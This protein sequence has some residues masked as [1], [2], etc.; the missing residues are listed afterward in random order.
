[1]SV[2]IYSD[3][4]SKGNPGPGGYGSIIKSVD[5][6]GNELQRKEI[7]AG[8]HYT[9]NNRMELMGVIMALTYIVKPSDITVTTDS[10]YVV[11]AFNKNWLQSWIKNDWKKSDG[12]KVKNADLWKKLHDLVERNTKVTFVWVK[13]HNGHPENERCDTLATAGADNPTLDDL[14]KEGD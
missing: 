5:E 10:S 12:S 14:K 3:G 4:S 13:G 6:K 11:N 1:M 2:Y 8:Y 9:T 7:S